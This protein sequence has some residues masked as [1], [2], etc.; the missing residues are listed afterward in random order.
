MAATNLH[1]K[2]DYSCYAYVIVPR[3]GEAIGGT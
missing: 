1:I 2:N 3:H